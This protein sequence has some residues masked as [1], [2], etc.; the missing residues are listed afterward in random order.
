[1]RVLA[2]HR[3]HQPLV[4]VSVLS[5]QVHSPRGAHRHGGLLLRAELSAVRTASLR[6]QLGD[7]GE[8]VGHDPGRLEAA[9][10]LRPGEGAVVSSDSC[11]ESRGENSFLDC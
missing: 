4:V 10:C 8:L 3:Q 5:D 2:H 7:G 11:A 1:M 9:T 6:Q